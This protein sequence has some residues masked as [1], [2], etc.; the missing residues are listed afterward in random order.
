MEERRKVYDEIQ[1]ILFED[2]ACVPICYQINVNIHNKAIENYAGRTFGV[3]LPTISW[4][5]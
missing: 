1:T 4:A 5:E 2:S 3:G